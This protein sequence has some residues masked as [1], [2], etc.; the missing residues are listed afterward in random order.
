MAPHSFQ[1]KDAE[2]FLVTMMRI[3][4]CFANT[5]FVVD[6]KKL[7]FLIRFIKI[8]TIFADELRTVRFCGPEWGLFA[9]ARVPLYYI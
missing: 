2:P 3:S 6:E 1:R 4:W 9:C 5:F 7:V 8:L